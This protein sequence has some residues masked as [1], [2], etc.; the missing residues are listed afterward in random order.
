MQDTVAIVAADFDHTP[1]ADV[2]CQIPLERDVVNGKERA[3]DAAVEARARNRG[4]EK[5]AAQRRRRQPLQRSAYSVRLEQLTQI[6]SR[7]TRGTRDERRG[8]ALARHIHMY[9][10]LVPA[11][12]RQRLFGQ[13]Q[14]RVPHLHH[15]MGVREG[16]GQQRPII[17]DDRQ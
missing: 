11:P 2:R 10:D 9:M 4:G 17:A 1:L 15:E 14:L 5:T 13:R 7:R 16:N 3:G 12:R 8:D 6:L